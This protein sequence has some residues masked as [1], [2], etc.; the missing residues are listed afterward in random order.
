M[1]AVRLHL[2]DCGPE[3]GPLEVLPKSHR[4]GRLSDAEVD[5]WRAE[6]TSA[7]C[8]VNAGGIILMRPLLLHR[9][10]SAGSPRHRR[11][12]HVEYAS[13]QLPNGLAW[14]QQAA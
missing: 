2:D 11:V 12:V 4:Y 6:H 13:A 3:N 5:L 7:V 14:Y 1:L 8:T 10:L 9:S